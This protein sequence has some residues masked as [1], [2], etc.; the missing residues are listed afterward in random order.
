MW[1]LLNVALP[2]NWVMSISRSVACASLPGGP[3]L[4]TMLTGR[5]GTTTDWHRFVRVASLMPETATRW[6]FGSSGFWGL[7]P[8]SDAMPPDC[9]HRVRRGVRKMLPLGR[10]GDKAPSYSPVTAIPALSLQHVA[11]SWVVATITQYQT[12]PNRAAVARDRHHT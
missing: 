10:S 7:A 12:T 4:M 6:V 1:M 9:P 3:A 5:P 11:A 8:F 2:V